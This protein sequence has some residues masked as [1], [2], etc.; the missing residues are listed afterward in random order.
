MSNAV[1]ILVCDGA[2][3]GLKLCQPRPVPG[4]ITLQTTGGELAYSTVA[5]NDRYWVAVV[6]ADDLSAVPGMIASNNWQPSW[7]LLRAQGEHP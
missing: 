3:A 7:D 2:L 5:Y 4:T 1:D 6:D